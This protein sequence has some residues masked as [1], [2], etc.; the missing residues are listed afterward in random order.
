MTLL[1]EIAPFSAPVGPRSSGLEVYQRFEREPDALAIAVVDEAQRPI[2]LVERNAFLVSMA[3]QYGYALWSKRPISHLMKTDP[4]VVDGDVTVEEFCGQVMAERPSEL[5]HGFI[6]TC[7]GRY[8]GVGSM[9]GLLQASAAQTA[10]YA[11]A[12]EASSRQANAAL[13]ARSRFLGVM[14]HEIRTPLSGVLAVAEIIK[15]RARDAE[16]APLLDTIIDSGAVLLRLLNDALDLSRA[17]HAGLELDE[18][19][20]APARLAADSVALWSSQAELKGVGLRAVYAGPDNAWVLGDEVRLRQVLNNLISNAMKF[21]AF[22]VVVQ[23]TVQKEGPCLKVTGEVLDDGPGVPPDRL[24]SI[25]EPFQQTEDGLRRGGAGLGLAVCQQILLRMG[26]E[27]SAENRDGGGARFVFEAPLYSV[28]A[29]EPK[30]APPPAPAVEAG[31]LRVLVVDDN[32]T[33][34]FI[35]KCLVEMFGGEATEAQDGAQAIEMAARGGFDLILMDINMPGLNGIEA[36]QAIRAL[37]GEAARAPILALT[38]NADP[39]DAGLYRASGMNGVVEK[40]IK[41]DLL[42]AAIRQ[43]IAPATPG[44]VEAVA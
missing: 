10:A 44:A 30:P 34:R 7:G 15:R 2:G 29:P 12:A 40:P 14:S 18:E 39:R 42:L 21:A 19:P 41:P 33:N 23:V 1:L 20:L 4:L 28:P 25:F 36:T 26:G 24:E 13:D 5:M 37:P 6:V 11:A 35:A 27:V 9:L 8:A 38:A 43:V 3:A 22:E 31:A 32:A 16:L 17:E